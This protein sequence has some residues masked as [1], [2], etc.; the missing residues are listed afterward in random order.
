[1][2]V[3]LRSM[4]FEVVLADGSD[5]EILILF[6]S[7]EEFGRFVDEAVTCLSGHEMVRVYG[8]SSASLTR[9]GANMF[10]ERAKRQEI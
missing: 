5:R 8:A 7:R 3:T 9:R 4:G 2:D 6:P 10:C 1:M